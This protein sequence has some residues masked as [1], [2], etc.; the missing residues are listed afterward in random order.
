M[1]SLLLLALTPLPPELDRP[2]DWLT[3]LIFDGQS[4]VV[5]VLA[6]DR[7]GD[8]KHV[9]VRTGKRRVEV[10]LEGWQKVLL[11][12]LRK[13]RRDVKNP[14]SLRV[15]ADDR[16]QWKHARDVT[17]ACQEAGFQEIGF[18]PWPKR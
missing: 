14:D 6:T 3:D 15:I 7:L 18:T 8:V 13:A 12:E 5:V 2:P 9:M 10:P 17:K 11:E 1:L 4:E 16:W